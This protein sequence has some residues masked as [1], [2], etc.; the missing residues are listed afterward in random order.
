MAEEEYGSSGY[1]AY[2]SKQLSAQR[3]DI[4]SE[5]G[6]KTISAYRWTAQRPVPQVVVVI[7]GYLSFRNAY[8]EENELLETILRE[9]GSLG[10]TFVLTANRVTDVFEK[11]EVIFPMRFH[12]SYPIQ[13]IIIMP[14]EDLPRPQANFRQEEV[15]SKGKCLH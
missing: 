8:P 1:S 5:A 6:V 7:D 13:A 14:W 10:I 4:I 9:G 12:L 11:L 2:C 15:W 3:K